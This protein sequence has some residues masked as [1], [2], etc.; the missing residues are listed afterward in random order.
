MRARSARHVARL[1]LDDLAR[2]A[3][4]SRTTAS[5]A[6]NRPDQLS[7][8]LRTR[9]LETAARLG[10]RGP[11]AAA[12]AL[13]RGRAGVIGVLFGEALDYAFADPAFALVLGGL[14]GASRDASARLLLVPIDLA[15]PDP[16][17][18]LSEVAADG[19]IAYSMPDDAPALAAARAHGPLVT[20]DQPRLDGVAWAGQDDRE[21]ARLGLAHL[22]ELGHE[23][24]ASLSYRLFPGRGEG[25][26]DLAALAR[27]A[28]RQTRERAAVLRMAP[29]TPAI[30]Q[31]AANT[32][33]AAAAATRDLLAG[34]DR[35]TA[36]LCDSDQLA[37]GVLA[38]AREL[39]LAVPSQLSVI[40]TDDIP[41][42]AHAV[43][44]LTTVR[45]RIADK[46]RAAARLLA[47]PTGEHLVLAVE[48]VVRGSTGPP[49][50]HSTTTAEGGGCGRPQATARAP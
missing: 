20:I 6:Y 48:L 9:V 38:V 24:I 10:Y 47:A 14:A 46:G 44:P 2:A 32:P 33:Q 49:P 27:S 42:A 39:G 17:A 45:Q 30:V 21:S 11:D 40:G 37:L 19:L 15:D 26:V 43:P 8:A 25:R 3:G 34:D 1:T 4:V 31:A 16:A 7:P 50:W 29:C 36:V 13:S 12:R 23:R 18:A 5:N 41:S 35:P 22:L 28:Y